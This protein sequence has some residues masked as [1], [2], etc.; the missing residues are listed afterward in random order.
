M[1]D[2]VD[3]GAGVFVAFSTGCGREV[4]LGMLEL[5][6]AMIDRQSLLIWRVSIAWVR[7]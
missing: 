7:S 3:G 6:D 1:C 2:M 4:L 5:R